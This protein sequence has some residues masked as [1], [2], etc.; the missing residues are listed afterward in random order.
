MIRSLTGHP[1]GL[2]RPGIV[3]G[4]EWRAAKFVN[5]RAHSPARESRALPKRDAES[6]NPAEIKPSGGFVL[7]TFYSS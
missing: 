5:A 4:L 3:D 1:R 7:A 2:D 6:K